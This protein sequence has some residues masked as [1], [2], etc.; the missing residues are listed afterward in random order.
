MAN[1]KKIVSLILFGLLSTILGFICGAIIWALLKIINLGIDCL[2]TY[3]P[4]YINIHPIIYNTII[5]CIGAI[6]IVL[7]ARKFGN[8][9]HLTEEVMA[10]IKRDGKYPYNKL[11]ICAIAA[12]VPLIFGGVLGPEAGLVGII[13]GLCCWVGDNL[14]YRSQRLQTLAEAGAGIAFSIV[15]MT[16]LAGI[17]ANLEP[18]GKD[19]KYLAKATSKSKRI[20]IYALGVIG[21]IL[22]FQLFSW[23][24]SLAFPGIATGGLPRFEHD[25][26]IDLILLAWLIPLIAAGIVAGCFYSAINKALAKTRTLF[27]NNRIIPA[28]I[29][30]ICIAVIGFFFPE[31][32][33][34]GEHT[35][36]PM[37][38]TWQSY[39][40]FYLIVVGLFKFFL[41]C[42]CINFGWRGGAIFPIIFGAT[43]IGY[44]F[45]L[46][47]GINGSFAVAVCIAAAYAY[48]SR[49]P[50]TVTAVLLLC[51][52]IIYIP[53]ILVT[54]FVAS[55][56]HNPF[57][58]N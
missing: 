20:I 49:Q 56:V 22:A 54:A 45:A 31:T 46:F 21:G 3:I 57:L 55:K 8:L 9:P 58:E 13:A 47:A 48:I 26:K 30:A 2:W 51:F 17:I 27:K 33:F 38:N 53:I 39:D 41:V 6:L 23:L 52:P 4:G 7:L 16:P 19:E 28:L 35:L 15:F 5:C 34:S 12:I 40:A 42:L 11:Y 36:E 14:K 43:S 10:I 25:F 50:L 37:I 44:A 18:Q 29:T 1:K 32:M 24:W